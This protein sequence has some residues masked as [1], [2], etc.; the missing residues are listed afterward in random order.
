MARLM[1]GLEESNVASLVLQVYHIPVQGCC[2]PFHLLPVARLQT[3]GV[4]CQRLTQ[5]VITL[6]SSNDNNSN[7]ILLSS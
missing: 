3:S 2:Q 7:V 6:L 5:H 1:V 4:L